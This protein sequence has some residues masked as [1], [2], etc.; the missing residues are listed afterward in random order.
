V[1]VSDGE[2][3]DSSTISSNNAD[4]TY[5]CFVPPRPPIQVLFDVSI[6]IPSNKKTIYPGDSFYAAVVI[7]KISPDGL[8]DVQIEY[9]ITDPLNRTVDSFSE[10]V[11]INNTV[12]RVP[13]LYLRNDSIA[14]NYTFKVTVFYLGTAAWSKAFFNV[15]EYTTTTTSS[16]TTTSTTAGENVTTTTRK[17]GSS[18]GGG[19]TNIV[20]TE[21]T[22]AQTTTT[23]PPKPEVS[24]QSPSEVQAFPGETKPILVVVEN[25]GN[26]PVNDVTISLTGELQIQKVIPE[27]VESIDPGSK[28]V[29]IVDTKYLTTSPPQ[30]MTLSSK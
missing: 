23:S 1:Q 13:V 17:S 9:D 30:A 2:A 21:N 7:T 10:M 5:Q 14:G 20:E 25:T 18:G 24:L 16:T 15:I 19:Y 3:T 26:I 4:Y 27:K 8:D 22:E 29:F 12:Y 6:D 11:A 28:A